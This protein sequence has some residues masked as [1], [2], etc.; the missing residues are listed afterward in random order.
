ME[1]AAS[2]IEQVLPRLPRAAIA[3]LLMALTL[4]AVLPAFTRLPPVDRA[5]NC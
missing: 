2:L 5:A 4:I 3:V 1:K